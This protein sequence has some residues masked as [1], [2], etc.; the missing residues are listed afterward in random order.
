MTNF[1]IDL[2]HVLS[3]ETWYT[4]IE[5]ETKLKAETGRRVILG[6]NAD[7]YLLE[8]DGWVERKTEPD[9]TG[10]RFGLARA[11]YRRTRNGKRIPDKKALRDRLNPAINY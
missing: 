11:Y 6:V 1:Q 4:A 9:L 2:L 10:E 7:L 8:R 3:F 5:V